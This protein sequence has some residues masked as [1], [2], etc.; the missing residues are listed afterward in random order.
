[1]ERG[2]VGDEGE[3]SMTAEARRGGR[4]IFRNSRLRLRGSVGAPLVSDPENGTAADPRSRKR[5][6]LDVLYKFS[7]APPPP[8]PRAPAFRRYRR[9]G[10]A[11]ALRYTS[12]T[13]CPAAARRR[14]SPGTARSRRTGS[15]SGRKSKP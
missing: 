11:T 15:R 4:V 9:S 5:L 6:H 1:M 13:R 3:G 12:G 8:P 7:T 2:I 14:V 10:S